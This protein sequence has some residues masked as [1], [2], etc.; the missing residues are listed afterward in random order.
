MYKRCSTLVLPLRGAFS[1]DDDE[2]LQVGPLRG[3]VQAVELVEDEAAAVLDATMVFLDAFEEPMRC[4]GRRGRLEG[5]KEIADGTGQGRVVVLDRKHIVGLLVADG[6]RDIGLCAHR[7][8][9]ART[10]T[11]LAVNRHDRFGSKRGQH[12]GADP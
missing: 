2:G 10:P 12:T 6:L 4:P 5:G 9:L 1:L 3:V 8:D 11:G 7:I